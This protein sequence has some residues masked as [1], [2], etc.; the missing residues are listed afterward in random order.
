[1]RIG[2]FS[3][4]LDK[5]V[6]G[7]ARDKRHVTLLAVG[8][9]GI[10]KSQVP[11]ELCERHKWDFK[12]ICM[13]LA[14]PTF[15]MGYPFR[16]NGTADHLPFGVLGECL[17]AERDT[18]LCLDEFGGAS[19]ET[20]KSALRFMQFREVGH[21]RLPDCV[22][23]IALSNDV[24][25]GADVMG[26]IEPMKDRFTSIVNVEP[27][28]EDSV[29]FGMTHEWPAWLMAFLRNTQDA[30]HDLK[31]MKSMQR[32]GATPRGWH[33]V[34]CLDND[35]LLD[36][37]FGVE[38]VHGAVGK[39]RGVQAMAF[40]QLMGD[41]PDID[42]IKVDP[43][44]SPIPEN[45]GARLLVAMAIATRMTKADFGQYLKYLNRMDAMF[46]AYS[47]RDAFR[48]ENEKRKADKLPKGW[49]PLGHSRDFQA[50]SMTADGKA[51]LGGAASAS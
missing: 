48:A 30:L 33:E 23:I 44:G 3:D 13:P 31:P 51:V 18:L 14:N 20:M 4:L 47:I 50:W 9:A 5:S 24:G 2:E 27:H 39:G 46:R 22:R 28:I 15:L 8:P 7:R 17:K 1:M 40:R 25:H 16:E 37:E 32:S 34:A 35:G 12:A 49:H 38:L 6:F 29:L 36:S 41:L 45:P 21:K 43:E 11:Q 19:G 42:V 26:I 10:G